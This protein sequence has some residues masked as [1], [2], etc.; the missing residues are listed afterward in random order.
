[1]SRAVRLASIFIAG[2]ETTGLTLCWAM[3]FLIKN[4]EAFARCRAE[5][6]RAAP[7]GM[8][9]TSEQLSQLVFCSAVFKETLRLR[10]PAPL[11]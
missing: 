4:P 7:D 9:S 6:L 2:T 5:A 11:L 1:A 10:T 3:Y 8:V